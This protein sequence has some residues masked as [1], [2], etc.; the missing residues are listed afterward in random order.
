[1]KN[2][3]VPLASILLLFG[4]ASLAFAQKIEKDPNGSLG[5]DRNKNP[6]KLLPDLVVG[7]TYK[8]TAKIMKVIVANKCKGSAPASTVEMTVTYQGTQGAQYFK[9]LKDVPPLAPGAKADVTFEIPVNHPVIKS[10]ADK[11]YT[12]VVDPFNKVKEASE[13]NNW[14]K[15]DVTSFPEKGGYCDPPYDD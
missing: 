15:P 14:W 4:M 13:G 12:F 5:K 9:L 1:M 7:T 2:K 8:P 6:V 3:M 10:L 11:Y